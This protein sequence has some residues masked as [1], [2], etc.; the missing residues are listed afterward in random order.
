MLNKT[1][2]DTTKARLELEKQ[3][4]DVLKAKSQA[5]SAQKKLFENNSKEEST[6]DYINQYAE[7]FKKPEMTG[8]IGGS[9]EDLQKSINEL[10]DS[11]PNEKAKRYR[12]N[13]YDAF[14]IEIKQDTKDKNKFNVVGGADFKTIEGLSQSQIN[15]PKFFIKRL[16]QSDKRISTKDVDRYYQ[17]I[18]TQLN[19]DK[20]SNN[21]TK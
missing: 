12:K 19:E 18:M 9:F 20:W 7:I 21:L 4:A 2:Q 13:L 3:K 14:S 1:N 17:N 16:L 5:L 8:Q 15:N 11:D 6:P 10:T